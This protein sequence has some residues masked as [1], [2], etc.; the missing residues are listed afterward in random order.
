MG[1]DLSADTLPEEYYAAWFNYICT[2]NQDAIDYAQ[3]LKELGWEVVW[4]TDGEDGCRC[5]LQKDCVYA[6]SNY[7]D[8][9]GLL[10]VGFSDMVENLSC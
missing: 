1:F 5:C 10:E 4:E 6:V 9:D 2:T 8:Y 7:Y 3:Q